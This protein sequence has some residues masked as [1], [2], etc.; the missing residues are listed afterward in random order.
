MRCCLRKGWAA[1]A[2]PNYQKEAA[3]AVFG[4]CTPKL[5][6]TPIGPLEVLGMLCQR[7]VRF[8]IKTPFFPKVAA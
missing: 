4:G 8:S 5:Q 1:Y 6:E 2:G 3:R 7:F